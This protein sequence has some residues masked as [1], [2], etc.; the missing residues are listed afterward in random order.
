MYQFIGE[1]DA[2]TMELMAQPRCGVKD[3]FDENDGVDDF[4]FNGG[5]SNNTF[6][7]SCISQYKI[8]CIR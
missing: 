1:L 7:D 4:T 5:E 2:S 6:R 8:D 3:F